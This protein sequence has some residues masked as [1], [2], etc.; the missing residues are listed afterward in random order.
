M[1]F[2]MFVFNRD[3]Q[4]SQSKAHHK[5]VTFNLMGDDDSEDEDMDKILGGKAPNAEKSELKS[6]FEKRQEKVISFQVS[7]VYFDTL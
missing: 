6:S 3:N 5:K 7:H 1:N 4:G 2:F